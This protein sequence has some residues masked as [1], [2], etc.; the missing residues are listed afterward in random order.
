VKVAIRVQPGARHTAVG[1]TFDGALVVRVRERAVEGRASKAALAAVAK[2]LGVPV[3][4][5][6]LVSGATSRTKIVDVPDP[7]AAR[8]AA[9][10][11]E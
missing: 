9:L 6:T 5:V 1:G 10:R 2:A 7:A 8:L 3:R 4:D 11:G